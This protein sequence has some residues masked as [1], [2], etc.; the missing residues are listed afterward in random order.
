MDATDMTALFAGGSVAFNAGALGRF[1]VDA[2]SGGFWRAPATGSDPRFDAARRVFDEQTAKR[3]GGRAPLTRPLRSSARARPE[4][5]IA[6]GPKPR[7]WFTF[8]GRK[9]VSRAALDIGDLVLASSMR[10]FARRHGQTHKP[11][12]VWTHTTNDLVLCESLTEGRFA[13]LAD[14][15]PRVHHIAAQP[16]TIQFPDGSAFRSHTPDFVVLSSGLHPIVIDVKTPEEAIQ[17]AYVALHAAAAAALQPQGIAHI[18]VADLPLTVDSNLSF[19]QGTAVAES[20][21]QASETHVRKSW[22]P[23]ATSRYLAS[24]LPNDGD[25]DEETLHIAIRQMLWRRA[26]RADLR[27]PFNLTSALEQS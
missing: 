2:W 17:P 4:D 6:A 23:G 18:V 13:V 3:A 15:D 11:T 26:L 14:H 12:A 19:F 9:A 25:L 20:D 5:E 21:Y 10:D 16:F 24:M 7:F 8:D 22:R 1:D 27:K